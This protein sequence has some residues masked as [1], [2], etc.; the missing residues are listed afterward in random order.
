MK[1]SQVQK[2]KNYKIESFEGV[3]SL[4]KRAAVLGLNTG[5]IIQMTAVYNHGALIK[6][7]HGSIAIGR[8]ILDMFSVSS[9]PGVCTDIL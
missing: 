3:H 4:A 8:D 5:A 1:L 9:E 6:T 7:D 2:G